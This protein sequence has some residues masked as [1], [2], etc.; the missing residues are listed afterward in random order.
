MPIINNLLGTTKLNLKN[1]TV[2]NG[3][4]ELSGIKNTS[5]LFSN[6]SPEKTLINKP[7][8][9]QT[10]KIFS[11][12]KKKSLFKSIKTFFGVHGLEKQKPVNLS[13]QEKQ[14]GNKIL[15]NIRHNRAMNALKRMEITGKHWIEIFDKPPNLFKTSLENTRLL[16]SDSYSTSEK[17]FL[18]HFCKKNFYVVHASNNIPENKDGDLILYSSHRLTEKKWI[19]IIIII[20]LLYL[21]IRH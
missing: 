17:N 18:S 14:I 3:L 5:V 2:N 12:K 9:T 11:I 4:I 16:L 1:K 15:V 7:H 21:I 20:Y 13:E 10:E 19:I 8:G 6:L